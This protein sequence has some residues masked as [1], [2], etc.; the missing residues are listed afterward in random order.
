MMRPSRARWPSGPSGCACSLRPARSPV[1][2]VK[3][4]AGC[5]MASRLT[6]SEMRHVLG[7][8]A[9]QELEPR[10]RRR[11]QLA[12]LH[13]RAGIERRRPHRLL[14]AAVDDD[15]VRRAGVALPRLDGQPGDRADRGQRLAAEAQ[16]GDV[17]Q[18]LVGELGGGVPLHRQRQVGRAH[19]RAVVGDADQREA[20]RR[21]HH[22][23]L[24]GAGVERVLDQLLDHARR[25]LDHLAGGDAVDGLGAELA[26]GHGH[27]WGQTPD[28]DLEFRSHPD[29]QGS[30][31]TTAAPPRARA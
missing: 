5:A 1:V 4:T 10:R 9:L 29:R 22:L 2:S 6:T 26:D 3:P 8:L 28:L 11:E 16:R 12:H 19:A 7:P 25:P 30:D 15:L 27:S 14:G 23:D 21:R 17:E 20:A 24:A 18:V 31:P 13:A